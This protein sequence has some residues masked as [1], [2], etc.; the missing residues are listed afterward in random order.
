M[1]KYQCVSISD[2]KDGLLTMINS[3][4]MHAAGVP[5]LTEHGASW[6]TQPANAGCW[7]NNVLLPAAV[8]SAFRK[9]F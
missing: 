8:P 7:Y 3:L 2:N 4:H 9:L 1:M 5:V 6:Q